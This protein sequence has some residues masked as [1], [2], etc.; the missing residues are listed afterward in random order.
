MALP[1]HRNPREPQP[2]CCELCGL[3]VGGIHLSRSEAEGLEGVAICDVTQNCR[4]VRAGDPDGIGEL[5]RPHSSI[6]N[7]RVFDHGSGCCCPDQG[8][9]GN[10]PP[11]ITE[12]DYRCDTALYE[13][14][15]KEVGGP[16]S[17]A[18]TPKAGDTEWRD[19]G[20]FHYGANYC[21]RIRGQCPDGSFT[22]WSNETCA[23]ATFIDGGLFTWPMDLTQVEWRK[24]NNLVVHGCNDIE[25][26]DG[27]LVSSIYQEVGPNLFDVDYEFSLRIKKTS[28][29]IWCRMAER[30]GF[31]VGTFTFN[32][33]TGAIGAGTI[34]LVSGVVEDET[35]HW[36]PK[37]VFHRTGPS[38]T[39]EWVFSPAVNET[40][41]LPLN[42]NSV[43]RVQVDQF[44]L[45]IL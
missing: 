10:T 42:G 2:E 9:C 38:A 39:N 16:W 27:I 17:F 33:T 13:L 11:L 30:S 26:N 7:S 23:L 18:H 31:T 15:R 28:N 22:A 3:E 43:N 20:P 37:M 1:S 41:A 6:G 4:T 25:D 21:Y 24:D 19:G 36:R 40:G 12:V 5:S 34:G 35:T 44:K 32:P 14:Q 8:T 29:N 45:Q